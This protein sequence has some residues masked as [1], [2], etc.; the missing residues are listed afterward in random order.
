MINASCDAYQ[1]MRQ[2]QKMEEYVEAIGSNRLMTLWNK[3]W[4][5]NERPTNKGND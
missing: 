4:G 5:N 3:T 1:D 2:A